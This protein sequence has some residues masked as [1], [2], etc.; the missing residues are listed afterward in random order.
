MA[1]IKAN[2]YGHGLIDIAQSLKEQVS[3]FGVAS[4]EEALALRRHDIDTP[5]LLFGVLFGDAI[6]SAI[7]ADIALAVSSVQQA[8]KFSSRPKSFANR[9][10]FTSKWTPEWDDLGFPNR[11]R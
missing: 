3:Y 8:G 2:A 5:I 7:Q 6:A 11:G 10:P 1:V 4:L 9:L